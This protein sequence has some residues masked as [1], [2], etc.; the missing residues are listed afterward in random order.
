MLPVRKSPDAEANAAFIEDKQRARETN[1]SWIRRWRADS[2]AFFGAGDV[3]L[4]GGNSLSDFRIRVAQS[5][6]RHDLTPSYWSLVGILDANDMV[7]TAPLWP[8]LAPDRVPL[9]NGIQAIPLSTF[10]NPARW[11]NIGVIR[12]PGVQL[13]PVD[14]VTRLREQR[15]II[16]IPTLILPWLGFVWGAGTGG[17]PLLNGFGVPSAVLV[18]TAYGMAEVE[19]TPGLAAASSCPEAIYQ[20]ARWWTG[21]YTETAG[22]QTTGTETAG[23][24]TTGTETTGTQTTG[25]VEVEE[26]PTHPAGRY[27]LRQRQAT[28]AEPK[29]IE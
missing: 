22:T 10:D 8:L 9:S 21:Y 28:Y 13:D 27:L 11:R 2:A 3:I 12:F 16:D 7:L 15:S 19:L 14:C 20:A 26:P 6:I 17:N 5:H 1:L 23:T 24:Q 18:E 4:L 25:K 29:P